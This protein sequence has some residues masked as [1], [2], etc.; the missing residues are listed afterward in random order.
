MTNI[1]QELVEKLASE[2][3]FDSIQEF[4]SVAHMGKKPLLIREYAGTEIRAFEQ[5]GNINILYPEQATPVQESALAKALSSG[6]IFDDAEEASRGAT[7]IRL[8]I[9]PG[10]AFA[11]SNPVSLPKSMGMIT[12]AC[13]GQMDSDGRLPCSQACIDNGYNFEKDLL[14]AKGANTDTNDVIRHHLDIADDKPMR[15]LAKHAFDIKRELAK[16]KEIE[17]DDT[18]D[19]TDYTEIDPDAETDE[20]EAAEE[21]KAINEGEKEKAIEEEIDKSFEDNDSEES[22]AA[23]D[24]GAEATD[25]ADDEDSDEGD[26]PDEDDDEDN[27][28][29]EN[30]EDENKEIQEF[31][32]TSPKKIRKK[33]NK[34]LH[35]VTL[36]L[37]KIIDLDKEDRLTRGKIL[38]M[39]SPQE[40]KYTSQHKVNDYYSYETPQEINLKS[41]EMR[42]LWN[43]REYCAVIPNKTKYANEFTSGELSAI[44]KIRDCAN[45]IIEDL[46]AIVEDA[47]G[48]D[49]VVKV[50]V[51]NAKE[52]IDESRKIDGISVVSES[53]VEK[54]T[55]TISYNDEVVEEGFFSKRPKKLKDLKARETVAYITVEL[56]AV[57]DSN[58]QAML[59]S[60]TCSKLELVDFYINCLDT[61]DARYV[62]PHNR[63]YLVQFQTDLNRLL[64]QILAIKPINKQ[65]RVWKV[66]VTSPEDWRF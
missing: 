36:D 27:D 41:K 48:F 66:N 35:D 34:H 8:T 55:N 42:D 18:L 38:K 3:K 59:S 1:S 47:D 57:R 28:D 4:A 16:L 30:D 39:Y 56:G 54:V 51:K 24:N 64:T 60:Y 43:T 49:K 65:D 32:I 5:D 23:E 26:E 50:I 53:K 25:T 52:L 20:E 22:Q 37:R 21:V 61:N 10:K 33:L 13:V 31:V 12:K 62:V 17:G 11:K 9:I 2:K 58:D 29:E 40:I 6:S 63:A 19:P 7:Y 44:K 14:L 45:D 46:E 15:D